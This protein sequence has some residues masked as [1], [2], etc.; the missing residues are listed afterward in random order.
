VAHLLRE[1]AEHSRSEPGCMLYIAHQAID[2]PDTLFLYEQY[3]P[4]R[5]GPPPGEATRGGGG[6]ADFLSRARARESAVIAERPRARDQ[7]HRDRA[8]DGG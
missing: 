4:R 3:V 6:S 7:A 8:V 5:T 2:A 1:V